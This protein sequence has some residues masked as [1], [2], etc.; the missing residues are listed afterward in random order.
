MIQEYILWA[1]PK[2]EPSINEK[3]ITETPDLKHL[4]KAKDWAIR[5]GF[6]R[7]RITEYTGGAPDFNNK[8][9][10]NI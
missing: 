3:L 8:K 4:N 6:D 1:T 5:Q 2:G 7:L 10:I 9:L